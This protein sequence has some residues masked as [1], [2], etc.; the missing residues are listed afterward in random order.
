MVSHDEIRNM[1]S[2]TRL[3]D[4]EIESSSRAYNGFTLFM[5][6]YYHRLKAD[7]T[8]ES[9]IEGIESMRVFDDS[10]ATIYS[11]DASSISTTISVAMINSNNIITNQGYQHTV[12]ADIWNNLEASNQTFWNDQAKLLN[13]QPLVGH[14][15][16]VPRVL[17]HN[18][19]LSSHKVLKGLSLDWHRFVKGARSALLKDPSSHQS[20]KTY[21]FLTENI[22][23]GLQSY[24]KMSVSATLVD[25]IFGANF[26][27]V[28]DYIVYQT[29]NRS[30]MYFASYKVL[31]DILEINN[32]S[33]VKYVKK[34]IHI[35][36]VEKSMS[37]ITIRVFLV[38]C[39][40]RAR[41]ISKY[42][43]L[44]IWV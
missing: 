20:S 26:E 30:F 36:V 32:H 19:Q 8:P 4:F 29:K 13:Q 24:R 40:M 25:T 43:W 21:K 17:L 27:E 9:L 2:P 16:E 10:S 37:S 7:E 18:Y 28:H 11:D 42:C 35:F 22:T 23:I 5:K 1:L 15:V 14:F 41:I 12:L 33:A 39:W 38:M 44:T 6:H 31:K 34:K 3:E